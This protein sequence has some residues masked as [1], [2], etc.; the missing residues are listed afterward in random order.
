L[1]T[2]IGLVITIIA[3]PPDAMPSIVYN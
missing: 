1:G 2:L 3:L